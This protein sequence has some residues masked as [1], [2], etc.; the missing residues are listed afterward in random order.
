MKKIHRDLLLTGMLGILMLSLVGCNDSNSL[1]QENNL[2]PQNSLVSDY[3]PKP[4]KDFTLNDAKTGKPVSL[5][6]FKGKKVFLHFWYPTCGPCL[7][8]LPIVEE[9]HKKNLKNVAVVTVADAKTV[10][11]I[12]KVANKYTFLT[13]FDPDRKISKL[14]AVE[15]Y[16]THAYLNTKGQECKRTMGISTGTTVQDYIDILNK[17]K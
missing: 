13:L 3:A 12:N 4:F 10:A 16:P 5:N 7:E 14:Y 6:S 1:K 11:D 17:I 8:D 15:G 2:T 9:L